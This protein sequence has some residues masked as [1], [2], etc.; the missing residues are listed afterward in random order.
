MRSQRVPA[1]LD[2][3]VEW[4]RTLPAPVR[5]VYEAG[6]TGYRL[7]RACTEAG[8]VCVARTPNGAAR[9]AHRRTD[10]RS[11]PRERCEQPHRRPARTPEIGSA[12]HFAYPVMRPQPAHMSRD[13]DVDDSRCAPPDPTPQTAG[14]TTPARLTLRTPYERSAMFPEA[15]H[16]GRSRA[17]TR[18]VWR[19]RRTGCRPGQRGRR[20]RRPDYVPVQSGSHRGRAV[21]RPPQADQ[22]CR[23]LGEPG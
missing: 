17:T 13:T 19:S 9:R 21:A 20:S 23:G 15:A 1:G 5:V 18:R 6:P 10:A 16:S 14:P 12:P 8:I 2:E 7:A 11:A 22:R 4:L 3:T